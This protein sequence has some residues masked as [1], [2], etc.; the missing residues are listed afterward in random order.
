LTIGLTGYLQ[1]KDKATV[2]ANEIFSEIDVDKN[3]VLDFQEF[4]I[5]SY[6]LDKAT[7]RKIKNRINE[8]YNVLDKDGS[9]G[10]SLDEFIKCIGIN[11]DTNLNV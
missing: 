7:L 3:D 2:R 6:K 11:K 1:D 4:V 10:V 9:G 5:V 8:L